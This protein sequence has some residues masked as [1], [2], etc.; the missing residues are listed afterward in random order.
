MPLV[1]GIIDP[2]KHE[3]SGPYFDKFRGERKE[4]PVFHFRM[5][6]GAC[7]YGDYERARA[8]TVLYEHRHKVQWPLMKELVT[9]EF[10]YAMYPPKRALYLAKMLRE[11]EAGIPQLLHDWEKYSVE[12]IKLTKWW[13]PTPFPCEQ[14]DNIR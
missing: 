7:Y 4:L 5:A 11:N 2:R 6:L 12:T 10:K 8:V 9:E 14:H 13:T 1:E 3:A